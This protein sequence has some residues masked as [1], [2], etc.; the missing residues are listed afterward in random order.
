MCQQCCLSHCSETWDSCQ[1]SKKQSWQLRLPMHEHMYMPLMMHVARELLKSACTSTRESLATAGTATPAAVC[2]SVAM[3][4]TMQHATACK[5]AVPLER[6]CT[7]QLYTKLLHAAFTECTATLLEK[8][9]AFAM[10]PDTSHCSGFLATALLSNSIFALAFACRDADAIVSVSPAHARLSSS[11]ITD[12]SIL[13]F[14]CLVAGTCCFSS[15]CQCA[16]VCLY[17]AHKAFE[18]I[19]NINIIN[20]NI[21]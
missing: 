13:R 14:I 9:A 6:C 16:D 17:T 2:S 5:K 10:P 1:L 11:C 3:Q 7:L 18:R 20:L 19:D 15:S 4:P 8:A 21:N 12:S